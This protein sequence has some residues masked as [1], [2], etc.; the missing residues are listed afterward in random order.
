VRGGFVEL[1]VDRQE[2]YKIMRKVQD[3]ICICGRLDSPVSTPSCLLPIVS[4]T[5]TK[6]SKN[7]P[8]N[9][10]ILGL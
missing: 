1:C 8:I 10:V 2:V 5:V 3:C 6:A 7:C 4:E 9:N